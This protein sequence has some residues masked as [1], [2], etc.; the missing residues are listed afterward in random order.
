MIVLSCEIG[1]AQV[2][3]GV[4][5]VRADFGRTFARCALQPRSNVLAH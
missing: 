3:V 1:V 4:S 5:S 2:S